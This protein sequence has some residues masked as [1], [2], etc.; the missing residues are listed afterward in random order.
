VTTLSKQVFD[1]LRALVA[2]AAKHKFRVIFSGARTIEA[3]QVA[4]RA[5]AAYAN[6][7][8]VFPRIAEF[9]RVVRVN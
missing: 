1:E 7:P 3:A 8:A 5:G 2:R 4:R 9:G 6:G